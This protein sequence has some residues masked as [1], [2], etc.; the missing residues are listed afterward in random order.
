MILY[1]K[2]KFGQ[3]GPKIKVSLNLHESSYI[4]QFEDNI[5]KY[6]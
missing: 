2:Y 6:D 1:L 5:Y 4:S 3:I